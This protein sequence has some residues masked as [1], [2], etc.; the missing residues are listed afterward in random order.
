MLVLEILCPHSHLLLL[1]YLARGGHEALAEQAAAKLRTTNSAVS[2]GGSSTGGSSSGASSRRGGNA[3]TLVSRAHPQIGRANVVV[4][5]LHSAIRSHNLCITNALLRICGATGSV[6]GGDQQLPASMGQAAQQVPAA[7]QEGQQ[8][9]MQLPSIARGL[10]ELAAF[11]GCDPVMVAAL[12]PRSPA[13]LEIDDLTEGEADLAGRS[14]LLV[15]AASSGRINTI[16][17]A[18]ALL[19]DMEVT[20]QL[21]Q[22]L[23]MAG[24]GGHVAAVELLLRDVRMSS[25]PLEVSTASVG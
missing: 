18:A 17:V 25:R 1:P 3:G 24:R 2:S 7:F 12:H 19:D 16:Q 22:A 9:A 5:A 6:A 20:R 13:D 15:A 21:P 23:C 8:T 10:D 14:Y 11:C 4:L